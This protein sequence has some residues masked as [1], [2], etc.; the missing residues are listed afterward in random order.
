MN[1]T[2]IATALRCL[3]YAGVLALVATNAVAQTP[4]RSAQQH[5]AA[6]DSILGTPIG[7]EVNVSFGGYRY[8]EPGT[9]SISISGS[10]IVGGYTGTWLLDT[11]RR[12]FTQ[13]DLRG[14]V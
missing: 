12:W 7:H 10:K 6:A 1:R 14:T 11:H 4:A 5:E 8:N 3:S 9:Q 2:T 13:T